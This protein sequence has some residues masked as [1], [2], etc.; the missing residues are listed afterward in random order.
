MEVLHLTPFFFRKIT[1]NATQTT[2]KLR[3]LAKKYREEV[4]NTLL[5]WLYLSENPCRFSAS[6]KIKKFAFSV[7]K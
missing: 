7:R 5:L 1:E 2:E 6:Q 3:S 4:S